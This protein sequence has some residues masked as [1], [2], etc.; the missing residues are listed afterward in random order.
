LPVNC[1]DGSNGL[2]VY[3]PDLP[4][5]IKDKH[6]RR[7]ADGSIKEHLVKYELPPKAQVRVD[8]PRLC[9][10]RLVDVDFP[11]WI[12]EGQKKA[13]ALASRGL[14]AIALLGVWSFSGRILTGDGDMRADLDWITWK[15]RDV[16]I[17]FDS[18]I[19]TK[20]AV[21]KALERLTI[22]LQRK[23]AHV[24]AIYLP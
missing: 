24:A 14:V 20:P 22:H 8:C 9:R 2:T 19:M 13:D 4:R 1:T 7:N 10:Q 11:L 21:R 5:V 18:D 6:R 23:G 3:R 15:N 12:T 17:V 16:R